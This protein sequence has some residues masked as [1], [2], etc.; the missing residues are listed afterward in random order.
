MESTES[1]KENSKEIKEDLRAK[2]R[3]RIAVSK[4]KR[5]TK[6]VQEEKIEKIQTHIT[7][8]MMETRGS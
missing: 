6:D 3:A 7:K 8:A 1:L 5:C 4:L 2:L